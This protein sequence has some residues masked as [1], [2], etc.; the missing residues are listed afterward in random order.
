MDSYFLSLGRTPKD[1]YE[2]YTPR[3]PRRRGTRKLLQQPYECKNCHIMLIHNFKPTQQC[4]KCGTIQKKSQ[5]VLNELQKLLPGLS[6][7]K[8]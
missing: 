4:P 6:D 8:S 3:L 5:Q 1:V 7:Q 2:E